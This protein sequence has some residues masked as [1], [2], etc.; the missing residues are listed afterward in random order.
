MQHYDLAVAYKWEF[1]TDLIYLLE[2]IM[3]SMGLKTYIITLNNLQESYD[4]IRRKEL[5]FT[6]LFDRASDEDASFEELPKLLLRQG[7]Y[8][9]N[10]YT[11]FTNKV[12]AKAS[13]HDILLEKNLP[14]PL[15][16]IA[17]PFDKKPELHYSDEELDRLGKPFVVKPSYYSGAG[18]AVNLFA[19]NNDDIKSTRMLYPDDRFLVQRKIYPRYFDGRRGWFRVFFFFGKVIPIW[20]DDNTHIF[21]IMFPDEIEEYG[22]GKLYTIT[23]K[24][25]K[26]ARL[27]YFSTEITLSEDGHFYLIDYVNEVCDF[28]FRSKFYDGV[29][30]GIITEFIYLMADK[31]L[32][33]Q[34]NKPSSIVSKRLK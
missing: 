4:K 13:M 10:R 14:A 29:P 9:I 24:L 6:A 23:R 33:L 27:D 3:Q 19:Y 32:S 18:E 21:T 26:L 12:V 8:I 20:W 2:S 16:Y 5:G 15:T 22:L 1:D 28:R 34:K 30:E 7:A 31:V 17:K 11:P 25:S